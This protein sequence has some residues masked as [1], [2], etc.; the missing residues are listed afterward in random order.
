MENLE[1]KNIT[2]SGVEDV[3]W[4]VKITDEKGL[5]YNVPKTLKGTET[6][7]KAFQVLKGMAG[8][9]IGKEVSVKFA[10]TPNGQGGQSRYV[11]IIASPEENSEKAIN[12]HNYT[13]NAPERNFKP[14]NTIVEPDWDKI[15]WGKCKYGF[16]I[17]AFKMKYNLK[18]AEIES[19]NWA[20]ASMRRI[21][22]KDEINTDDIT[23][24]EP[25]F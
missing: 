8:Y 10:T 5:K 2:I 12:Y 3:Q 18:D 24:E 13:K 17:E 19:E 25:P 22:I 7:T 9:G 23:L 15:S 6:E 20:D 14:K 16:L 21:T 4:G 11:R 1:Q